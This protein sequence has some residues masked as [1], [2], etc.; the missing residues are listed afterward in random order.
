M[1][2]TVARSL[3]PGTS[4]ASAPNMPDTVARSLTA[5]A[6]GVGTVLVCGPRIVVM[7]PPPVVLTDSDTAG[8]SA[9]VRA[10]A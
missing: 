7:P 1:P 2:D 4:P 8:A 10:L 6:S 5:G 3:T 9:A